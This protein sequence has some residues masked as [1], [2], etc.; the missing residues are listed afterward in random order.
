[1]CT[2]THANDYFN[3]YGKSSAS[4]NPQSVSEAGKG[5][6]HGNTLLRILDAD[7]MCTHLF[8]HTLVSYL[9]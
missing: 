8:I 5:Q 6:T 3:F 2:L 4:F 9:D 1:V 7:N